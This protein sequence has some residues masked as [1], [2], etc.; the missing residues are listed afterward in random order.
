MPIPEDKIQRNFILVEP[1]DTVGQVLEQIHNP[2]DR[3]AQLYTFVVVPA[4]DGRYLALYW[5]DIEKIAR[6][7][8]DPRALLGLRLLD[9]PGLPAPVEAVERDSIGWQEAKR[10]RYNQ[11]GKVLVVLKEGIPIGVTVEADRVLESLPRASP[12]PLLVPRRPLEAV[13]SDEGIG[14]DTGDGPDTPPHDLGGATLADQTK[15]DEDNRVINAW[16]DGQPKEQPLTAGKRYKLLFDVGAPRVEGVSV[17]ANLAPIFDATN[18]KSLDVLVVL[19]SED[20][21]IIGDFQATL[22]VPRSGP[23]EN[24]VSFAVRPKRDGACQISAV[25]FTN[26]R[27]FQKMTLTFQVGDLVKVTT[28]GATLGSVARAADKLAPRDRTRQVTLTILR[29]EAGYQ[30]LLTNGGVRRFSLNL[31]ETYLE[32]LINKAR[33]TLLGIVRTPAPEGGLPVYQ[34]PDT[35][36]PPTVA[37]ET[38]AKLARLGFQLFQ[39]LFYG[40]GNTDGPALGNLLRDYSQR[41]QLY[42]EIVQERFVFPWAL[43]YDRSSLDL[44]DVAADGFWGFKHIIEYTPEFSCATLVNID[45]VIKVTG[46]LDLAFVANTTI[47]QELANKGLSTPVVQPQREF[48]PTL[49]DVNVREYLT[50][51]DLYGLLQD[52]NGT[53]QLIYFYCHAKSRQP[54]EPGGVSASSLRLSDASVTLDDLVTFAPLSGP[55]LKQAPLVFLNA[56]ES[57]ELSPYLYDGLVPYLITKGARGV[58]GTEV[59]TPAYFAAEFARAFLERFTKGD[60]P[61]GE[62]LRD[63]RRSYIDEKKN[64]MGLLYALYSSGHV[65]VQRD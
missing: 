36:I 17:A 44:N 38:L 53:T 28:S 33:E 5:A 35:S 24:E 2:S 9:L 11:P 16:L 40:P 57:A 20:F 3:N 59:E 15:P 8:P 45:P 64:M 7:Q 6:G 60:Q 61:L 39:Q 34:R 18:A 4:G 50:A 58:L 31:S 51:S 52:P 42:I 49:P 22:V 27:A 47:D 21:D 23:S 65:V 62:L 43:L 12:F 13:G 19:A 41:N 48:L 54:G 1:S 25:F 26:G 56:C 10:L 46:K 32:G 37:Q 30:F 14:P 55:Q 63:L 29:R